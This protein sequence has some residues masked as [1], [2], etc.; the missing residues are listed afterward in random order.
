MQTYRHLFELIND[1]FNYDDLAL[2]CKSLSLDIEE[3]SGGSSRKRKAMELQ[4]Y[5]RR[6]GRI[7]ELLQ[8]V[9]RARLHLDLRPFGGPGPKEANATPEA[10]ILA[11]PVE[12][13]ST[14]VGTPIKPVTSKTA[15]QYEDFDIRIGL[16]HQDGR[17]PLSANSPAGDTA[18]IL[19]TLPLDDEAFGD[20]V[21]YLRERMAR[22]Q[23]AERL[24][25]QLRNFLFPTDIWSLY[26]RSLTMVKERG[27]KGLRVRI[28]V[29][30]DSSPELSQIPWEYCEGDRTYLALDETTPVV[31]YIATDRP[32]API[33]VPKTV[34]I[35]LVIASPSDLTPLDV[36][37]EV[38]LVQQALAPLKTTGLV[39]VQVVFQTTRRKLF[40]NFNSFDPHILHFIGHGELNDEGEGAL[41][42][43]NEAGKAESID[44]KKMLVLLQNSNVKL[45][46][47]N[48]CETAASSEGKAFM[49]IAP[50][51]VWAGIPA[52][53]AM[54]FAIP[55]RVAVTFTQDLY[56][57]LAQGK[58]LDMA[59]TAARKGA[60][61]VTD[62]IYWA[63]PV[64]FMRAPDGIIWQ[65]K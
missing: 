23:H 13:P 65:P 15:G 17:Y 55:D 14:P 49:G 8:E 4:E 2:L 36:K 42:L 5:M 44:A 7:D 45:V 31:R 12:T 33:A 38:E 60:Y 11:E 56:N 20:V 64:L 25:K 46:I 29:S 53:I 28:H 27:K 63:I 22:S 39:D 19:Q 43:E 57:A 61:F 54:Q 21:Y 3:L 24:G 1:N 10:S 52:V 30:L 47:L 34:R 58:P 6:R 48:A 51:L 59:M 37:A 9:H 40:D 18:T 62:E 35:L 16:R 41:I 32:P 50:R 26:G